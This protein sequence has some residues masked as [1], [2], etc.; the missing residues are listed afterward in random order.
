MNTLIEDLLNLS[1]VSRTQLC[2]ERIDLSEMAAGI[3]ADLSMRDPTR[4]VVVEIAEGLTASCD[5]GL[6]KVALENLLG[7]AWKFTAKEPNARIAFIPDNKDKTVFCVQDNGA[8]FD[9]KHAGKLFVPF[10]RLHK[11][12]EFEGTGIGLATVAR[13]IT[14]HGGRIWVMSAVNEGAT[15][16]FTLDG[17]ADSGFR[18][19]TR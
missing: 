2:V 11:A 4:R 19:A 10:Q 15:F 16:F 13:I 12:S 6:I 14:R 5:R 3:V 7:N 9:Q 1:K 18:V 17:R 8:G